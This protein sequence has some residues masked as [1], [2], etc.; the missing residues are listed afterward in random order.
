MLATVPAGKKVYIEVKCGPEIIP[1]LVRTLKGSKLTPA[2]QTP[3]ISFKAEVILA[4]K[5]A[6]AAVPAYWIPR[7]VKIRERSRREPD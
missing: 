7:D 4:I 5:Q 2:C 3:V 6:Y 1:E